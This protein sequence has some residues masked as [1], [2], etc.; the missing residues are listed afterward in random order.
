MCCL[1]QV[2]WMCVCG[3]LGGGGSTFPPSNLFVRVS[4]TLT[5]SSVYTFDLSNPKAIGKYRSFIHHAAGICDIA[6]IPPWYPSSV[7][8]WDTCAPLARGCSSLDPSSCVAIDLSSPND[9]VLCIAQ[10]CR[11]YLARRVLR[12]LLQRPHR[13]LLER[14]R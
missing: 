1:C 11:S 9:S 3:W 12:D 14:G 4:R 7:C 10:C 6:V 13:A 2:I 8:E 5:C